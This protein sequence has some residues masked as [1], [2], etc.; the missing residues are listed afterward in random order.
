M[1][2]S[3]RWWIGLASMFII[4]NGCTA[5][6]NMNGA[7]KQAA[8]KE[9]A[10]YA[11]ELGLENAKVSCGGADSDGDGYLSCTIMSSSLA[12]PYAAECAGAYNLMISGCR[13]QKFVSAPR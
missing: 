11:N 12:Q 6:G 9:A 2:S 4:M 13:P 7:S 5:V 10:S 8:E 1:K 3:I